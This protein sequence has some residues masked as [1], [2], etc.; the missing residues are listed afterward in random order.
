MWAISRC[1]N[2]FNR[3]KG[4]LGI[5]PALLF[6]IFFFAGGFVQSFFI[7]MGDEESFYGKYESFWAYKEL[8]NPSFF[9]SLGVTVA[10]AATVSVTAGILGFIISLLLATMSYQRTWLQ[11]LFQIPFGVPHL[12]AA[13]LLAQVFM[14]TGWYSR[15]AF[16]LG[17]IDSYEAFPILLHD[18]WGVG[19]LLA[20]MWKEIPFIVLLICPFLKKILEEW[21]DTVKMLGGSFSQMIRWVVIPILLPLW[22]GGMWV[23][24]AFALGAYEI[25]ALMARTSFG[26]IP[27]L[28]WQEYTQF[29]LERQP[30]A[31]A[32]N[33]I[34]A[35]VS[36]LIGCAL[37]MLQ[38]NWYKKGRRAWKS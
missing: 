17:W 15:I 11:I 21:K 5:L 22:V 24:F 29:G 34:L 10:M 36:F 33:I 2:L 38:R 9:H 37:L 18:Q 27:V 12:L 4:L 6:V 35:L 7:S 1:L 3:Y 8:W 25:P 13:Y 32:M 19:V 28:A 23:V 30:I 16:H 20:Y 26:F 31:F 14:Q